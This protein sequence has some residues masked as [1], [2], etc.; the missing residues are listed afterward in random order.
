M[1]SDRYSQAA[2]PILVLCMVAAVV[3]CGCDHPHPLPTVQAGSAQSANMLPAGFTREATEDSEEW[4]YRYEDLLF[5]GDSD[6]RFAVVPAG[7]PDTNAFDTT[8]R[9]TLYHDKR[10]MV[11]GDQGQINMVFRRY[12][13][14][15]RPEQFAAEPYT[16]HLA[17]PRIS[18]DPNARGYRTMI[19]RACASQGVNFAGHYTI[20]E[21]GCGAMCAMLAVV[22]RIDGRVYFTGIPFDTLDGHYGAEY[23]L[24]S[25]LIVVNS[26]LATWR[27]GY[28]V[29]L[30]GQWP[31][32]YVWDE[33][34]KRFELI[35]T[36]SDPP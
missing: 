2:A 3:I 20:A 11:H 21:W 24:D 8:L 35:E 29:L 1:S 12:A 4:I 18:S 23:S 14:E 7:Q 16:G 31:S 26:E 6:A 28:R 27:K 22:D 33:E 10:F 25:R 9:D 5:T 34:H 36:V 13:S 32:S 17:D 19:R 30:G 15:F